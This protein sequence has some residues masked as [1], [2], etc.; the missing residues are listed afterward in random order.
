VFSFRSC[1]QNTPAWQRD[2]LS[3]DLLTETAVGLGARVIEHRRG[4]QGGAGEDWELEIIEYEPD[5]TLGIVGHCGDM[6]LEERHVFIPGD[7]TR[8]TL[9]AELTG[10]SLPFSAFQKRVVENLIHLKW[11][12]EEPVRQPVPR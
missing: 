2:A 11:R 9:A 12:L 3:V 6:L 10:S 1:L 4:I 5:Q 8:Y 7:A